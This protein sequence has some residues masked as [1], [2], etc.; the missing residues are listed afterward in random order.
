MSTLLYFSFKNVEDIKTVAAD[1]NIWQH[2]T[3]AFTEMT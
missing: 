2:I 1:A 3:H